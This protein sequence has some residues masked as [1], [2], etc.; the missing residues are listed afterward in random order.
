MTTNNFQALELESRCEMQMVGVGADPSIIFRD[1][2]A[3]LIIFD[4]GSWVL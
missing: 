4:D 1:G 3:L 2:S